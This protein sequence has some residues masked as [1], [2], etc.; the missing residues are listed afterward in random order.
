[1]SAVVAQSRAQ[2]LVGHTIRISSPPIIYEK[3]MRVI[4]D[5]RAGA[6]DV[7]RVISEDQGLTVRVLKVVNSAFF[8]LPWKIDTVS[9]AVRAI[10]TSQV[11]DLAVATSVMTTFED[12]P[13]NLFDLKSFWRHCLS[14]GIMARVLA[15]HRGEGNVERFLVAGLLH[16]I[17]KLVMVLNAP[18]QVGAAL[19]QAK[20]TGSP[21][22]DCEREHVGCTHAQVGGALIEAWRFPLAL[23]EAV[24]YHHQPQ[25]ATHFPVEAAAVHVADL[26]ANVLEWGHGGQPF[27]PLLDESAL[28]TLGI[29]PLLIPSLIEDAERQLDAAVHLLPDLPKR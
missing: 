18:S 25:R 23:Q 24:R 13:G 11:R 12:I 14:T 22:T 1:M 9:E 5:P 3:L 28:S 29:E 10:G 17:G 15:G 20:A 21:L 4:N 26:I 19:E 16:D 27:A 8:S 2:E 7:A 6:A